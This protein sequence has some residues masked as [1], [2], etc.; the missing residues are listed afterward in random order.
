MS[1]SAPSGARLLLAALLVFCVAT[2]RPDAASAQVTTDSLLTQLNVLSTKLDSV[3]QALTGK[4]PATTLTIEPLRAPD[5]PAFELLGVA[6]TTIQRPQTPRALIVGLL[7]STERGDLIP[8]NY[9]LEV[10]PYWLFPHPTL[11]FEEYYNPSLGQAMLQTLSLS[12][13]TV[14]T[15]GMGGA[16]TG[17]SVGFGFRT[18]PVVGR[19]PPDTTRLAQI[20]T[21]ILLEQFNPNPD[22]N[23]LQQLEAQRRQTALQIQE[24]STQQ[25]GFS[26]E[27]AGAAVF[28]FPDD[29]V[30]A[31]GLSRLGVWVTPG[32]RLP[33]P[34]LDV[35][36]VARL[37]RDETATMESSLFDVGGRLLL[38]YN[39]LALSAEYVRQFVLDSPTGP[40]GQAMLDDTYRL[41][42]TLEFK[43][44]STMHVVATL[45]KNFDPT[46][47][48]QNTLI[49]LLGLNIG[50]G[51][52]VVI[53]AKDVLQRLGGP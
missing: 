15:T 35:L 25:L 44:N 20:S 13:A 6:P 32:Y 52:P 8:Q 40:G 28:D 11:A 37:I 39:Q 3:Q 16:K 23:K 4:A 45:G 38:Q 1:I 27:L 41:S 14:S 46:G 53:D 49:A 18:L 43:I 19:A 51:Q 34:L 24:Q 48:N 7:S 42:T 47:Q 22:Q 5:A 29:D 31:G 33:K 2:T 50:L 10:A 21:E 12:M 9:A 36:G 17:T 26:L 30:E